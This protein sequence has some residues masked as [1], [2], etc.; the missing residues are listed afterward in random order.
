MVIPAK[1]QLEEEEMENKERII[2]NFIRKPYLH[3]DN[4][5]NYSYL[6]KKLSLEEN[7][8]MNKK[9]TVSPLD[10]IDVLRK[11]IDEC[12]KALVQ[13]FQR[14]M[15]LVMEVLDNK[16]KNNL[17]ILHAQ[18]EQQILEKALSNLN[19]SHFA[20]EVEHLLREILK[21]SR[22]LQS[23]K[24]FPY[25][26]VLVGFMG[27]GKSTVGRDLSRKLEMGCR[28]TDAM[29]QEKAGMSI[30]EI[31]KK[32][33]EAHFRKLEKEVVAEVSQL[34]NTIIFCGGGVVLK[35]EN[36]E[37]LRQ[38]G[39]IILLTAQPET[40]YE[41]I[42][43]DDTRPV[44]KGQMSLEG[45]RSLLKQRNQAYNDSADVAIQT[46]DK[47]VDEISTQIITKLYA[48]DQHHENRNN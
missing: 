35:E 42:S 45:I 30:K 32:F 19:E 1:H 34:K 28:D 16:R 9:R 24:L 18:R 26:I 11:E 10:Q 8:D 7:S 12:D 17:P 25:N 13:I 36:V 15:E 31:F 23:K 38:N 33:G 4:T 43:Q 40:L 6:I 22:G 3:E 5:V 27:T 47:S 37:N 39:K 20:D 21:I 46:D 48:M 14:R 41:R 44:L 29:I 2:S